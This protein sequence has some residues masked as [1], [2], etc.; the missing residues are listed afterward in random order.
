MANQSNSQVASTAATGD[1]MDVLDSELSC[2]FDKALS[3]A[4]VAS[5]ANDNN[6]KRRARQ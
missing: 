4:F 3:R 2:P 5:L 6:P 1:L